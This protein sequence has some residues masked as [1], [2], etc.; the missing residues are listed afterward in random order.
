MKGAIRTA[1]GR[2]CNSHSTGRRL[3]DARTHSLGDVG[4]VRAKVSGRML[5]KCDGTEGQGDGEGLYTCPYA[6]ERV[7][8]RNSIYTV[9]FHFGTWSE[10]NR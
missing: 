7:A 5:L 1:S 4:L 10:I 8:K 9:T 6:C 2:G 3:L